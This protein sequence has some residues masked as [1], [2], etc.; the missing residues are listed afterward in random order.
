M[1]L[2]SVYPKLLSHNKKAYEVV[3]L[4]MRSRTIMSADVW[5][6][7]FLKEDSLLQHSSSLCDPFEMGV[8]FGSYLSK[9]TVE[10]SLPP[11]YSSLSLSGI[12][13]DPFMAEFLVTWLCTFVLL[14]REGSIKSSTLLAAGKIFQDERLFL[15]PSVLVRIY[16]VLKIISEANSLELRDLIL[17]WQYIHAWIHIHVHGAFAFLECPSYLLERRY[18]MVMQLSQASSHLGA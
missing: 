7:R 15:A 11:E 16:A 6:R 8:Q 18:T 14:I 4:S 10:S 5:I 3:S 1:I 2:P 17:P 12:D 9:E 13:E